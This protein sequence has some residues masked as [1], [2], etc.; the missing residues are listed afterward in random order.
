MDRCKQREPYAIQ[1]KVGIRFF[2]G[3]IKGGWAAGR[4]SVGPMPVPAF[5]YTTIGTDGLP[6]D[7]SSGGAAPAL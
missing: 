1:V 7:D 4:I 3:W 5:L 2:L 6:A